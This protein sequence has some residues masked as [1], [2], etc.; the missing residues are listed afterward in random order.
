MAWGKHSQPPAWG[1]GPPP[2]P[3]L[4][5][6]LGSR[7]LHRESE[8]DLEPSV[9][10]PQGNTGE[11]PEP[12]TPPPHHP[13]EEKGEGVPT[14]RL[15]TAESLEVWNHPPAILSSHTCARPS[16]RVC[17]YVLVYGCAHQQVCNYVCV[18]VH[19]H[20][21]VHVCTRMCM[22]ARVHAHLCTNMG[23]RSCVYTCASG[24]PGLCVHACLCACVPAWASIYMSLCVLTSVYKCASTSACGGPFVCVRVSVCTHT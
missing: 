9:F 16:V 1:E 3:L 17:V 20:M 19:V 14:P 8:S 5:A 7:E 21:C 12:R 15:C 6:T 18:C 22:N 11:L 4:E 10:C 23:T 13:A 24:Y 2:E